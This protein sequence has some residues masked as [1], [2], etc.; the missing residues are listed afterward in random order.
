V[1]GLALQAVSDPKG[2]APARQQELLDAAV[3][4][5]RPAK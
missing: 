4:Q 3:D 1:D 2:L 5:L